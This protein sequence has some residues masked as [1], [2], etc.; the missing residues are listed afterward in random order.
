MPSSTKYAVITI[1]ILVYSCNASLMI[2][3]LKYSVHSEQK[4]LGVLL[5]NGGL[6]IQEIQFIFQEKQSFIPRKATGF[7]W[8]AFTKVCVG[9]YNNAL[10]DTKL[11]KRRE[12]FNHDKQNQDKNFC[13]RWK[14]PKERETC[15]K[16]RKNKT[17]QSLNRRE[18]RL[19]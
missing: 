7:G 10:K 18:I 1:K 2:R 11:V 3:D 8:S 5:N 4:K 14:N 17:K 6:L 16:N 13:L 19:F 15:K 12:A 9:Y